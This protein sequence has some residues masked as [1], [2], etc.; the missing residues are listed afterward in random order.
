MRSSKR[1]RRRGQIAEHMDVMGS[2]GVKKHQRCGRPR[3]EA[4][5]ASL[6]SERPFGQERRAT[7]GG[8]LAP[9]KLA[10]DRR[11]RRLALPD[12]SLMLGAK[13]GLLDG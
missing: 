3:G 5:A 1:D 7:H 10:R 11:D 9:F 12:L 6:S 13:A 8:R 4:P 2:E